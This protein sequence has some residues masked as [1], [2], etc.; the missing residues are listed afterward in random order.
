MWARTH[1]HTHTHT[2]YLKQHG[3]ALRVFM[4]LSNYITQ[5]TELGLCFLCVQAFQ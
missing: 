5:V 2:N 4:A 3:I 1:T